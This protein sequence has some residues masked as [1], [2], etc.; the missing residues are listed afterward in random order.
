MKEGENLAGL[1]LVT[2]LYTFH[3]GLTMTIRTRKKNISQFI[4]G[5]YSRNFAETIFKIC[6]VK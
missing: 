4:L 1:A 3:L 5:N 6:L 2:L